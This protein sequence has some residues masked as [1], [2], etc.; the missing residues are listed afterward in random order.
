MAPGTPIHI[1]KRKLDKVSL[2]VIEYNC[3]NIKKT[4]PHYIEE[5]KKNHIESSIKW[6]NIDGLHETAVLEQ[7]GKSFSLHPL[8][9]ED[10]LNT[11]QRPKIEDYGSYI[12]LVTKMLSYD[13]TK[14]A[15]VSEQQSIVLGSDF[16]ITAGEKEGDVFNPIRERLENESSRIRKL[17]A[18]YLAY[19]LLDA[20]VDNYFIVL[21]K[22]GDEIEEVEEML[23]N[24]P[25]PQALRFINDLKRDM[26]YMHKCIWPLREVTGILERGES[27]LV[28]ESTHLYLRDVYDHVI[29]A[30]DTAET[31]RDILSGLIDIYLSSLSNKMNEIMKVLTMISTLFIPLTFLAGLYGMNFKFMPELEWRWG[32]FTI[33]G[34]MVIVTVSMLYFFKR[35]KWF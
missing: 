22:L 4:T 24:K 8:V 9:V 27:P 3:N 13:S 30:M 32:Y 20:I 10:M 5:C 6:I 25:D 14:K 34:I 12:F 18:D 1:G 33:L 29:Q 7:L 28:T 17:G 31:Y 16:V 35:K 19:S 2:G 26:L 23:I 21:E 11:E 15:I